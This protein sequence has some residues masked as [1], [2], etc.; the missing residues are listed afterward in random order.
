MDISEFVQARSNYDYPRAHVKCTDNKVVSFKSLRFI[1][2]SSTEVFGASKQLDDYHY[3]LLHSSKSNDKILGIAS[4][5]YWGRCFVKGRNNHKQAETRTKW[6]F[7]GNAKSEKTILENNVGINTLDKILKCVQNNDLAGAFW[8]V[9][10]IPHLGVSFGSKLLAFINPEKMGVYDS[11]IARYLCRNYKALSDLCE[12][13]VNPDFI[14]NSPTAFR[15]SDKERFQN[16][17]LLLQSLAAKLN[18]DEEHCHWQDR[19]QSKHT[20][21]AVDVERALF[22]MAQEEN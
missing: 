21:R 16:Y 9:K 22:F 14:L 13:E 15:S 6:L 7:E 8:A 19:D 18:A 10:E 20:W 1:Q 17:S 12:N 4:V 2:P 3:N 11:H 5:Q